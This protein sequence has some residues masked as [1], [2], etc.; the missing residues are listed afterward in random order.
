MKR[1][2]QE[3]DAIL[4]NAVAGI[5]DE[6]LDA[7]QVAS[8]TSRVWARVS[9]E[10]AAAGTMLAASAESAVVAATAPDHIRNCADFQSIIPAYLGGKLSPARAMLLED[11]THECIPCRRALKAERSGEQ[12][13]AARAGESFPPK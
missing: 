4:D 1:N 12:V 6:Q 8:S 5:R 2:N 10:A 9:D 11:H 13:A 3:L 7:T